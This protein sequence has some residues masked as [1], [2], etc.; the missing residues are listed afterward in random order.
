MCECARREGSSSSTLVLF[1]FTIFLLFSDIYFF[2]VRSTVVGCHFCTV[3]FLLSNGPSECC[4]NGTKGKT[5]IA[6]RS[7]FY[8]LLMMMIECES[9]VQMRTVSCLIFYVSKIPA[10][11][12]VRLFIC[13]F[14]L[15]KILILPCWLLVRYTQWANVS[16]N[17]VRNVFFL[18]HLRFSF[19][20]LFVFCARRE[21]ERKRARNSD[22]VAF[23]VDVYSLT[24]FLCSFCWLLNSFLIFNALKL[25]EGILFIIADVIPSNGSSTIPHILLRYILSV[26]CMHNICLA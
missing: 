22:L 16:K 1:C 20:V 19:V 13:S 11:E 24:F 18:H 12:L 23:L 9:V 7:H 8:V 14:S 26:I 3:G 25:V 2:L 21:R 17:G 5:A 4:L 10:S 6:S 15:R